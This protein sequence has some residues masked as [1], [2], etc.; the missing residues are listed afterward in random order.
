MEGYLFECYDESQ[1]KKNRRQAMLDEVLPYVLDHGIYNVTLKDISNTIGIERRTLYD[2][3]KTKDELIVDLAF[4]SVNELNKQYLVISEMLEL[5][6]KQQG[7]RELLKTILISIA[8]VMY[9]KYSKLFNFITEFDSFYHTLE[10]DNPAFIRYREIITGFKRKYHYLQ[11][12]IKLLMADYGITKYTEMELIEVVE[13]S[14]HAYLGRILIKEAESTRYKIDNIAVYVDIVV[15]GLIH[16]ES[17]D[18][19]KT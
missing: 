3:Y 5:T 1:T 16:I 18:L 6:H 13:Q 15:N 14:F 9:E 7:A 8:R 11:P 10:S 12:S 4:I 19:I 2:Y 17:N